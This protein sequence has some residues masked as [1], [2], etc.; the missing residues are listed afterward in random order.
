LRA[1]AGN[2][3]EATR[4]RIRLVEARFDHPLIRL[5]AYLE[6]LKNVENRMQ[7]WTQRRRNEAANPPMEARRVASRKPLSQA[8]HDASRVVHQLRAYLDELI[9]CADDGQI[10]SRR[11]TVMGDRAQQIRIE[12]SQPG[13]CLRVKAVAFRAT[14]VDQPNPSR[15]RDDP[16][17][18]EAAREL[19]DPGESGFRPRPRPGLQNALRTRREEHPESSESWLAPSPFRLHPS[20]RFRSSDPRDHTRSSAE[21]TS[22]GLM[23]EGIGTQPHV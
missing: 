8:L 18:P 4:L 15:V 10:G 17:V 3:R 23:E 5:D 6:F 16:V 19:Y 1:D 11:A 2:P 21:V 14:R 9:T 20:C 7:R 13:Q 12:A 22:L